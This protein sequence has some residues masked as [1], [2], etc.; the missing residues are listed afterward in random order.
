MRKK[1]G[2]GPTVTVREPLLLPLQS[3]PLSDLHSLVLPFPSFFLGGLLLLLGAVIFALC[4][5]FL[6]SIDVC[7]YSRA[8]AVRQSYHD[9]VEF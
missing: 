4:G 5:I 2:W 8:V 9:I 3:P 1:V 7:S 6:E